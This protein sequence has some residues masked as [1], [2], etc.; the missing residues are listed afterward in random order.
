[1]FGSLLTYAEMKTVLLKAKDEKAPGM[2][3]VPVDFFQ[4]GSWRVF[5]EDGEFLWLYL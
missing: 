1:M 4:I 5:N 3:G 2:D